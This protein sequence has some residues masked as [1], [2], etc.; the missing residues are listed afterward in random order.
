MKLATRHRRARSTGSKPRLAIITGPDAASRWPLVEVLSRDFEI[1]LVG[2]KPQT[3]SYSSH[4]LQFCHYTLERSISP[5]GDLLSVSRLLRI[6]SK[7]KPDVVHTF[8]TKPSVL[9]R[10]AASMTRVPVIIGTIP[11]IGSL[12]GDN[13]IRTRLIRYVYESLQKTVCRLSAMTVFQNDDDLAEFVGRGLVSWKRA[14]V[15]PGS[16]VDTTVYRPNGVSADESEALRNELGVPP[17]ALVVTMISRVIK[18]KGVCDFAEAARLLRMSATNATYFLLVGEPD[19]ENRDG[20]TAA[21]WKFAQEWLHCLGTRTDVVAILGITDVFVLPS[22]YREGIPRALIE[23]AA[24][25]KALITTNYPGCRDVV[26]HDVSGLIVPPRDPK[27]LAEA[28]D[29]LLSDPTR[30]NRLGRTARQVA[31]AKFDL[32]IV[33]NSLN[34]LYMR[35]LAQS[36][37]L[38]AT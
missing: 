26:E 36:E 29:G 25:G 18:S 3:N 4:A 9:G 16:G 10:L 33:A 30:R 2:S 11:G 12:Y 19:V 27:S 7:V 23:A 13:R 24:S 14:M 31:V 34:Q 5:I 22:Y 8:S 37:G 15:I 38:A 20:L 21:E 32:Q 6:L 1:T 17:H 28:I 35:L